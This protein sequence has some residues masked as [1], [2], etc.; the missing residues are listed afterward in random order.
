MQE[1][2][3]RSHHCG[4]LKREDEGKTVV[5]SGWVSKRR[6]LGGLI[7]IDLRDRY[8]LTQVVFN[9]EH[10]THIHH[11]AEELRAEWVIKVTGKVQVRPEGMV[12]VKMT[13]GEV[14]VIADALEVLSRSEVLP[15]VI[16]EES[17][18]AEDTRL[19]YRY[20]DL[21]RTENQKRLMVRHRMN[22][23]IRRFLDAKDFVEIETPILTKATPEGARDYLVPSRV[24]PGSFYALPQSPQLFKQL[25]M[26]S[27]FDRYYQIARC[28][29]DE[30]LRADRQ[31]EFTQLDMELSF[32]DQE[33]LLSLIEKMI[34]H[35]FQ[36]VLGVTVEDTFKRLTFQEVMDTYGTDK[37]DLRWGMTLTKINDAFLSSEFKVLSAVIETGG[38]IR[39]LR[40]PNKSD[41]PRSQ[42]D[43]WTKQAQALGAKGMIWAKYESG[44]LKTSIDKFLSE[45]EKAQWLEI[46]PMEEG[47]LAF[48]VADA[49]TVTRKVLH[50]ISRDLISSLGLSAKNP[51]SFLWVTDFPLLEYNEEDGRYYAMHHP[52]TRPHDE[53]LDKLKT[54]NDL[55][56]VRAQAY[57]LV[58]NGFELGGGSMRIFDT[59]TQ[60]AMFNALDISEKE[61]QNKFGFFLEALS[62]G[63]PPHGGIAFG[64]D[65]LAML[66]SGTTA[67]RDVI[68]FPKT[69]SASDLMCQA[70]AEVP[71][72]SL[73]ELHIKNI[74]PQN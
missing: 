55:G 26:I 51:F 38:E 9:P 41:M 39:A 4:Q 71:E 3:Y 58:L 16:Q 12:N 8:G 70:P 11:L 33:S 6:D 44:A 57:D 29:R 5:L 61:A 19:K 73:V 69:Q 22:Q 24:H 45:T 10:N 21:R 52:F 35:V 72:A 64:L 50:R 14:E 66:L 48:V 42:I 34:Q 56:S 2:T 62:Y 43:Q 37:P 59:A 20:L 31:P 63:A 67:I 27:G 18:V 28:F 30:D 54:K 65:R 36:D 74:V 68:A 13:T 47:D 32:T 25:L 17:E 53:D 49:A 60:K 23:S 7:F 40:I 15:F 1:V 46:S